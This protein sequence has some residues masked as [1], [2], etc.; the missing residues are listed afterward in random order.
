MTSNGDDSS[1]AGG[2]TDIFSETSSTS[3]PTTPGPSAAVPSFSYVND[4]NW[5]S[6]L[7]SNQ[8]S[9][10]D[11]PSP[12]VQQDSFGNL[13]HQ[14]RASV[15]YIWSGSSQPR[16]SS[17]WSD[18]L[19]KQ[20]IAPV[21]QDSAFSKD[22]PFRNY[23]S[24]SLAIPNSAKREP[25]YQSSLPKTSEED[26]YVFDA[27]FR[28]LDQ[29]RMASMPPLDRANSYST[30]SSNWSPVPQVQRDPRLSVDM[31]AKG[32][33]NMF[34]NN[35]AYGPRRF[36]AASDKVEPYKQS[37]VLDSSYAMAA[38]LRRHSLAEPPLRGAKDIQA[39]RQSFG[40]MGLEEH[41]IPYPT[42]TNIPTQHDMLAINEYF[43]D[44]RTTQQDMGK[45]IPLHQVQGPLYTVQFKNDRSDVFYV[46]ETDAAAGLNL[47]C[48]DHVIVEADRGKDLG[49]VV[50]DNVQKDDVSNVQEKLSSTPT[51]EMHSKRIYRL[52]QPQEIVLL[53]TK[54]QDEDKALYLCQSKI[55]RMNLPMEVLSAEYQCRRSN[56]T[57]SPTTI[58]HIAAAS[59]PL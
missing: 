34:D 1:S 58:M 4:Q 24:F 13:P 21:L 8:K 48:G 31:N 43:D 38:N 20:S 3:P 44:R 37:S 22:P 10:F 29:T 40:D 32:L 59:S 57:P 7:P 30:G 42:T 35:A 36:S 41:P 52:A 28:T 14:R 39:M 46:S 15:E 18:G 50:T 12:E 26:E 54:S 45:G 11:M 19:P 23:R 5:T 2:K 17:I 6:F 51:R 55:A 47:K 16:S 49:I 33:P 27:K 53:S 9:L 56:G 25:M